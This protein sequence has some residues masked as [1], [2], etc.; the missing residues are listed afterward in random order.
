M[1]PLSLKKNSIIC[2]IQKEI[3][4]MEIRESVFKKGKMH[5]RK[6]NHEKLSL[7]FEKT[8]QRVFW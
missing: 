5:K 6:F 1:I 8:P 3:F 4:K 7:L 2:S